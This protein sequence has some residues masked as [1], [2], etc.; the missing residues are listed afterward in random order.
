M[1]RQLD[2]SVPL[3]NLGGRE[4]GTGNKVL[5]ILE[6]GDWESFWLGKYIHASEKAE[7]LQM[8]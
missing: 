3:T 1:I 7:R 2:L 6:Q 5:I 8:V 4:G